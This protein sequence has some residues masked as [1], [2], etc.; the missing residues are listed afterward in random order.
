MPNFKMPLPS[1]HSWLVTNEVGGYECKG[2]APWPD[3]A[4]QGS[5]YFAIDFSSRTKK[6]TSYPSINVPVLATASGV[7]KKVG[8]ASSTGYY[9]T[10]DHGSGYLTRSI[11]FDDP[12]ARKNGTPLLVGD[13]VNQGDQIGLMGNRGDSTGKHLHVNFWY[14]TEFNGGSSV[15]N[16]TYITMDGWLLKSFQTECTMNASEVALDWNRYYA[17]QNTPTGQ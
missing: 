17:S 15:T 14:N 2:V 8:Y 9:I 11:H 3:T 13:R 16:L 4:H 1:G 10:I 5:N 6:G 12:A 7:V